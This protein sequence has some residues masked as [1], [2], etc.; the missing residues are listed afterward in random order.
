MNNF[1][2]NK[3]VLITGGLGFLGSNLAHKLISDGANIILLD[4]MDSRYGGNYFNLFGI[5]KK[6]KIIIGDVT[7][8]K[9]IQSIINNIDIIFHFAAQVS[10]IDSMK[11]PFEDVQ[12]TS[13]STL[14]I[15]EIC[16]ELK[17]K[18]L[19][20]FSSSRM[21]VGSV[22][23]GKLLENSIPNPTNLYGLHKFLSEKYL[24]LYYKE[25]KIP[26]IIL[27]IA[28]PYGIRQQIKH[29]KYS[30][31]GYF[32]KLAILDSTITIF[33][34]GKQTRDYVFSEDIIIS[35][36][37][38]AQNSQAIGN[39]VNIG[40][41]TTT[42]FQEMVNT[43]VETVGSGKIIYKPFPDNYN[44]M[45]TGDAT[46]DITKLKELTNFIPKFDL[47]NGIQTTYKYY[48]ENLNK[49]LL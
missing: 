39:T 42:E 1:F 26:Y 22:Q 37:K 25:F 9:L 4:N 49:Y 12:N 31:V 24:D 7:D 40:S 8:K 13:I 28:N 5:E 2:K 46:M 6:V 20:I 48:K 38:L 16:K 14:I 41:G 17:L 33:G 27:R 23:N 18:P 43:V 30:L 35:I 3:N 19:I 44:N 47:K 34:N 15:L 32:I 36:Y 45:E 21:V 11:D 10:Y 29:S